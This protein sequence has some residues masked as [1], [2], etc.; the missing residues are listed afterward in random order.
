VPRAL[1]GVGRGR[2]G[3]LSL[4]RVKSG[5][6]AYVVAVPAWAGL[7]ALGASAGSRGE[8]TP[9]FVLLT[10][11]LLNVTARRALARRRTPAGTV[12][13][14]WVAAFALMR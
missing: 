11:A 12:G 13:G 4:F 3:W 8:R 10:G 6:Y 9:W 5:S 7:G 2:A 14:V 1:L